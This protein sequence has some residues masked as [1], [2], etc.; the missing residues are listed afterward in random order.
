[1]PKSFFQDALKKWYHHHKRDLPWRK[2]SD[3]YR[4]WLSEIMLQQTRVAQG[5]PYYHRF[6]DKFRDVKALAQADDDEVMK[7]WE[8]LGYYSRARNM[9]ATARFV[10]GE[11]NGA[12]PTDYE[13]IKKLKGVGEYTA[14]AIASFAFDKAHAVVD[15]NVQRVL[16]R[17]L[18]IETAVNTTAGKKELAEAAQYMLDLEQP[19]TYNQAIMEFGALQCVPRN[20]GCANCV[21]NTQ[22]V[23]YANGQVDSL[24][25]K[26]RKKYNRERYL[27]YFLIKQGQEVLV[28]KRSG[29]GIWQGL[30]QF[31]L[32]EAAESL[33]P[34]QLLNELFANLKVSV[35]KET[36]LPPHKLSHQTLH[37][38]ILEVNISGRHAVK[39][40]E[41]QQWVRVSE[42]AQL[43]F[44]RPLRQYLDQIQ[45]TLPFGT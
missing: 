32:V 25:H 31:P 7:L 29:P 27:H 4:I 9:L 2:T 41:G 13:D 38:R 45:L 12:F 23:A 42:L 44:P 40:E 8:G 1:M 28:E 5:L 6:V 33:T 20:P 11:L 26:N 36:A 35:Q 34:Q 19:A 10:H 22:C 37:I 21:L 17:F 15:G 18:G 24:P 3:P 43:A 14:A 30:F 39:A 16:A